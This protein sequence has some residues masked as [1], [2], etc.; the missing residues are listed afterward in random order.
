MSGVR[1]TFLGNFTCASKIIAVQ[2]VSGIR[3]GIQQGIPP[4]TIAPNFKLR[5]DTGVELLSCYTAQAA[6]SFDFVVE[7]TAAPSEGQSFFRYVI[8]EDGAGT[9]RY[10]DS[11]AATFIGGTAWFWGT[12][13][14][15]VWTAAHGNRR[16]I[17]DW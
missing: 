2:D 11:A 6:P 17:I 12:G 13:A 15:P 9:L 5:T 7:T 16:L 3:W 10:Y 8:V 14:S 4:A 1:S